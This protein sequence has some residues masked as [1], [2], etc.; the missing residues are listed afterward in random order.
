MSLYFIDFKV[1]QHVL[2]K[3]LNMYVDYMCVCVLLYMRL[4]VMECAPAVGF[5]LSRVQTIVAGR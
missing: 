1:E 4:C 5:I 2:L 3:I